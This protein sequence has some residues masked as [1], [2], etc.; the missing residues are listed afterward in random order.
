[1]LEIMDARRKHSGMTKRFAISSNKKAI[2]SLG[3]LNYGKI[4]GC[5]G[6]VETVNQAVDRL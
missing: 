4:K 3:G 6:K 2:S 1:M 5:S